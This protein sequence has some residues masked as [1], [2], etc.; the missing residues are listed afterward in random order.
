VNRFQRGPGP[1]SALGIREVLSFRRDPIAFFQNLA[2]HYG[3]IAHFRLGWKNAYLLNHPDLVQEFL[4]THAAK[5]LRGPVMQRG[6]AIMGEGLL[7]SEDPLHAAQRRMI[8]PAFHRDRITGYATEMAGYTSRMCARWRPGEIVDLHTE[9]MRVTLA[10]LGKTLFNTEID[11]D[12]G[13]IGAAV[14]ELMSLVDLVFVPFSRY[15][16]LPGLRRL[17]RV[18][19]RLDRLIYRLIN[20]RLR[21]GEDHGDLLSTL[22]ES[23]GE[24]SAGTTRQVRDECLT[25]LLA[26]HET[27]AN[28]L[29][30]ALFLLAHH[31]DYAEKVRIEVDEIAG[32]RELGAEDFERLS[33][34]RNVLA[35][36]MRLY[37][38]VWVLGRAITQPCSIGHYTA[39]AGSI[40]F[41]SQYLLHRDSRFFPE[42]L[43][44]HP[45]RFLENSNTQRFT[46]FPF[47]IGPRR[48]IGEG[49]AWMEGVLALAT[50][51]RNWNIK[52]LPQTKLVL[53]AK[54]TLRPK[55]PIQVKLTPA[56]PAI[57]GT[58][59][60]GEQHA[61]GC[62]TT[63]LAAS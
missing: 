57:S 63:R 31:P 29:T 12:A 51:V 42:P 62:V 32:K 56:Q 10:I 38:P 26:G 47:G 21:T 58:Q 8:Q 30:Y 46:Y 45:E 28:A 2:T 33:L 6:R 17:N 11:E 59:L 49:F 55:F 4:V 41:V 9:M 22:L 5:H 13:K 14:T 16:P 34:T 23:A 20:E 48:C 7:T 43:C 25:I 61:S 53:D 35:E 15:L 50:I 60:T 39:P 37:P 54:I 27:V 1:K 36:S 44:F 19:T 3:D 52:L 24:K 40:L 18:R